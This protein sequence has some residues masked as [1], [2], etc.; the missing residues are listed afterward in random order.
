M[1]MMLLKT[2][3]E[4]QVIVLHCALKSIYK[5]RHTSNGKPRLITTL[6]TSCGKRTKP[7]GNIAAVI[8]DFKTFKNQVIYLAVK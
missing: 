1:S 6:D 3:L 8:A 2:S 7:F 5:K 4:C